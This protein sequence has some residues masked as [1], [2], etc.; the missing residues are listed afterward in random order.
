MSFYD[1]IPLYKDDLQGNGSMV[2]EVK[3]RAMDSF[4]LVLLREFTHIQS[5][6]VRL[7]DTRYF[8]AFGEKVIVRDTEIRESTV[9]NLKRISL[10][11]RPSSASLNTSVHAD[12]RF[13]TDPNQVYDMLRPNVSVNEIIP[14][15]IDLNLL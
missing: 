15:T 4:F 13:F 12:E 6:Q 2:L 8:Y 9:E 1:S 5:T 10:E 11:T 14:V 7:V 3:A